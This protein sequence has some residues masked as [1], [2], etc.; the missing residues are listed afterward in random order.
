MCSTFLLPSP[1]LQELYHNPSGK[2]NIEWYTW[3][4]ESLEQLC[5]CFRY[6]WETGKCVLPSDSAKPLHDNRPIPV[7]VFWSAPRIPMVGST[8]AQIIPKLPIGGSA[9]IFAD[10]G[11][12]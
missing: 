11:L 12:R 3:L 6:L 5:G 10:N 1:L 7:G 2:C 8:A 9:D 4:P